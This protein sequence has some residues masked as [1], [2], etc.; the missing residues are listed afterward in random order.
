MASFNAGA[1]GTFPLAQKKC[2]KVHG[3]LGKQASRFVT[4]MSSV[5]NI[6][7]A[8]LESDISQHRK[9]NYYYSS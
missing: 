3:S 5:L 9:S 4:E 8:F 1:T 6:K 7:I 2:L